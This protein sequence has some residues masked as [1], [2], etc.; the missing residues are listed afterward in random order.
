MKIRCNSTTLRVTDLRELNESRVDDLAEG[1]R[2]ALTPEIS[3]VEFD[4]AQ[5]RA[6]DCGTVEVL[7]AVHE[8]LNRAGTSLA[9]RVLNPPP[10][11]RQLFELVRLHH[12]FEIFP[13]RVPGLAFL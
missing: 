11:V 3:T 13:P 4:L 10:D 9:W 2:E 8:E 12:L 5:L 6:I 7:L 1:I